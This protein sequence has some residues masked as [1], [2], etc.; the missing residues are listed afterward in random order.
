MTSQIRKYVWFGLSSVFLTQQ[1]CRRIKYISCDP[2]KEEEP[3]PDVVKSLQK[4][5]KKSDEKDKITIYAELTNPN[6][7]SRGLSPIQLIVNEQILS[8]VMESIRDSHD[9]AKDIG[10]VLVLQVLNTPSSRSWLGE[11]L[12]YLFLYESVREPTRSL[13]FWSLKSEPIFIQTKHLTNKQI[14]YWLRNSEVKYI[15]KDIVVNAISSFLISSENQT[16]II[17][18]LL[19]DLIKQEPIINNTT[20]LVTNIVP[21]SK[22]CLIHLNFFYHQFTQIYYVLASNSECICLF[23]FRSFKIRR[24]EVTINNISYV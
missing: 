22:V 20:T 5:L 10:K 18:P 9:L 8:S 13:I 21:Y 16:N 1:Q 15:T 12:K 7:L 4:S 19:K 17:L 11:W 14:E 24:N 23:C 3:Q 2:K 6:G